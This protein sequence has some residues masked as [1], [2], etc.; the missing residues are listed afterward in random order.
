MTATTGRAWVFGDDV[1]TDLLAPGAY[2]KFGIE[3]IAKHC[4][5]SLDPT[6]AGSVRAGDVVFGGRNF[7]AGSSR[8]QAVEVLR[9]LGVVA[10]IAPS[11]AGL[12][13]RNG[14][15]LG[16]PLLICPQAASVRAGQRVHCDIEAAQVSIAGAAVPLQCE[17]IPPHLIAMVRDGGLVPHLAR[18]LAAGQPFKTE[19]PQ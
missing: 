5:E 9:H 15:N 11:F 2:M 19:N 3:E 7:G 10:V 18:K 1:N 4:L 8:E 13:Y 6:F 17:P 16:L 12:F 14:F